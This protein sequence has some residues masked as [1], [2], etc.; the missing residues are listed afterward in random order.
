MVGVHEPG[1][2]AGWVAPPSNGH[3]RQTGRLRIRTAVGEPRRG[4]TMETYN[5]A[6]WLLDRNIAAGLA[7]ERSRSGTE[8]R[9]S[10]YGVDACA[11]CGGCSARSPT[12]AWSADQR[13]R[14]RDERLARDDRLVPRAACASGSSPCRCRRCCTEPT[15]PRSP[16]TRSAS[17]LVVST[18]Y[19]G[20]VSNRCACGADSIRVV[21]VDESDDGAD[22]SPDG[23]RAWTAFTDDDRAAGGRHHARSPAFWLYS[24]GTTGLS[25]GRHARAR[26][27]AGDVRHLRPTG[28]PGHA[29]RPVPVGRQAVLRLRTGQLADVPVRGR[30]DVDP[31]PRATDAGGDRSNSSQPRAADAV[32]RRA[33]V[34][35]PALLDT[36]DRARR[37]RQRA[38][39]GDRGRG[40]P[41]R[42]AA[43]ASA[44]VRPSRCSTASDRPRRC[45]SS[46]PTARPPGTR[47]ERAGRRRATRPRLLDDDEQ[48]VTEPR[49]ARLPP[50]AWSVDRPRLLA[51]RRGDGRGVPTRRMAA[52]RRRVHRSD[53]RHLDVPRPQQRH[54]QGRRHLGLAGRGRGDDRRSP[55]RARGRRRRCAQ[56]N[57][58]SRRPSRSSSPRAGHAIDP[59]SSTRTAASTW[60]RSSARVG[61]SS[62]TNCR[63]P[64]PARSSASSSATN[65]PPHP[66][67]AARS[68]PRPRPRHCPSFH[69]CVGISERRVAEIPTQTWAAGLGGWGRD[70]V[71]WRE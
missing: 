53:E 60:R 7:D 51:A 18:E 26:Q 29:Q 44:A 28:P 32:L 33:R 30:R 66:C 2:M 31:R 43:A 57:R 25:E 37:V 52:H 47:I 49:H 45:T 27:H 8:A 59:R 17:G 10:S 70:V 58:D 11:S 41:G 62:S 3:P 42:P 69:V 4:P 24:S 16:P 48:D 1:K 64:P 50:R 55:R 65:S 36:D 35:S 38:G 71:A 46:C 14:R 61:C 54:D 20:H 13:V 68:R 6:T 39:D 23:C 67:D 5:A 40:A 15:S 19:L 34:S 12:S 21:H 9:T 56:P 63:R 22:A